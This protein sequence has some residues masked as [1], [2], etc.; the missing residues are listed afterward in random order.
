MIAPGCSALG[1]DGRLYVVLAV[2]ADHVTVLR[3]GVPDVGAVR[4]PAVELTPLSEAEAVAWALAHRIVRVATSRERGGRH[5][6][7]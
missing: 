2:E 1:S 4:L 7:E 6:D 3:R 5:H